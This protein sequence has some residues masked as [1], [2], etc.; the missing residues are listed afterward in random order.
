[1][2]HVQLPTGA[3]AGTAYRLW[4]AG[5]LLSALWIA[6][7]AYVDAY[8]NSSDIPPLTVVRDQIESVIDRV[9]FE[10]LRWNGFHTPY[11]SELSA[12]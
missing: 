7:I 2:R 1:M 6:T 5:Y 3:I 9:R 10:W 12:S 4:L 11:Q 8:I